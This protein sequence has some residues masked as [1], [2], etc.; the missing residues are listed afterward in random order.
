MCFVQQLLEEQL[1]IKNGLYVICVAIIRGAA[2][3]K[4]GL[5]LASFGSAVEPLWTIETA[6]IVNNTMYVQHF[7]QQCD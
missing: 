3:H 7:E 4:N 5:Y 6:R 2:V 1:S